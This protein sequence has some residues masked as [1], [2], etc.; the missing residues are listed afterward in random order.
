MQFP[1]TFNRKFEW[2]S[3]LLIAATVAA[4][5]YFYTVFPDQI[6]TH[7]DVN[8]MPDQYSGKAFAAFFLPALITGIYL[9]LTFLPM[10]DP[11]KER[12]REFSRTYQVFRF[13][14]VIYL[15]GIYFA[16]SL[17]ALGYPVNIADISTAGIGI[18]FIVLG[19]FMPKIK[20]TWF[21][22]IR[23]PWTLSDEDI[24]RQTHRVGGKLFAGS[25]LVL[26]LSLAFPSP[27]RFALLMVI[28][29]AI[30]LFSVGYSFYLWRKKQQA[31]GTQNLP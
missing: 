18:M 1:Y 10:I 26:L 15:S 17:Y 25:G 2:I 7:F 11:K 28:V 9:L 6:P 24:W 3:I 12:Y 29:A 21:V 13:I 23:T 30:L 16:S 8:G 31:P 14:F 19:N 5:G 27:W 20:P 4:G 22:G